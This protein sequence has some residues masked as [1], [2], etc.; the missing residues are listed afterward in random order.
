MRHPHNGKIFTPV[1]PFRGL[2]SLT[3]LSTFYRSRNTSFIETDQL[4]PENVFNIEGLRERM[5]QLDPVINEPLMGNQCSN[6][7]SNSKGSL[8]NFMEGYF[9]LVS[10]DDVK[11]GEKLRLR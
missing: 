11:V 3:P 8:P 9:V 2:E 7:M 10:R 6:R 5:E 4:E 1:T